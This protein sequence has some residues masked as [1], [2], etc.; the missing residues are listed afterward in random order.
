MRAGAGVAAPNQLRILH[1]EDMPADAELV[2]RQLHKA[3]MHFEYRNAPTREAFV[4]V[5]E[6]FRPDV[7]LA[8]FSL[9]DFDGFSAI[10]LVKQKDADLPLIVITGFLGDEAAVSLIKAGANDY[11]LKDR[12]ARLPFAVERAFQEA[13]QSRRRKQAEADLSALNLELERRV[14]ARTAEVER[15]RAYDSEVGL[16]IQKSLLLSKPPEVAGLQ[17]AALT[18]PS[19][20]ID[21]DFYIFISQPGNS[22]DFVV[23]DVMGKGIPAALLAAGIRS[24]FL[25][26]F[27]YMTALSDRNRLPEPTDVVM[28]AHAELAPE[29]IALES[30]VSL[31]YV[32]LDLSRQMLCMVDCGH[33]GMLHWHASSGC[34]EIVHGDGLPLGVREGEM[35]AQVRARFQPGDM[36]LFFSDGITEA[37]N[38]AGESFGFDR[39]MAHVQA[40]AK[41]EPQ[42]LVESIHQATV[43]FAAS[44]RL[45]D[46]LTSVAIRIG[47]NAVVAHDALD[48]RS[49]PRDLRTVRNFVRRF[50]A[51]KVHAPLEEFVDALELAVNEAASNIMRHAYQGHAD[52]WI[53][54][55]AED[56]AEAVTI[57]L[58]HLGQ[59]FQPADDPP[60]PDGTRD[61]GFGRYM[62]ARSVDQV[63][64]YRD[65]RGRNCIYLAKQH[66]FK[67]LHSNGTGDR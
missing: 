28:L 60:E 2:Q 41:L 21:G 19:H 45:T 10:R 40:N 57:R 67:E 17:I 62:I 1:L 51:Q 50:C 26:S 47:K 24:Q 54:I 49:H 8:D 39:L 9:P 66:L 6:E 56:S 43:A 44:G 64:Y 22:M 65:E 18:I 13:G 58:K 33:T 5:L 4:R 46:D 36:L 34:C 3:G 61:C 35:F 63:R 20:R 29:L 32:R 25:K 23:G 48:I 31:C 37:R 12:L 30:F 27:A 7:V 42:A 15:L 16:H 11:I 14:A 53:R 55:E 59:A 38:T 52:Q